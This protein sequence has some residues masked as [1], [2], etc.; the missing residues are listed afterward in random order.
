MSSHFERKPRPRVS[1]V[2]LDKSHSREYPRVGRRKDED[3]DNVVLD[4]FPPWNVLDSC[5]LCWVRFEKGVL[6]CACEC[7]TEYA[8]S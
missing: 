6:V 7:L 4:D 2:G 3:D 8:S 1:E 5:Q